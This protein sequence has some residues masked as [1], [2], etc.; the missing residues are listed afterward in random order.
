M[1]WC[2]AAVCFV[3][4]AC[5]TSPPQIQPPEFLLN[6]ALFAAPSQPISTDDLFALSEPMKLYL[7]T[8]IGRQARTTNP[9]QALIHALY[10]K[11]Q[12][13][14]RYDA[15]ATRNAAQAFEARAGNC[16]S[17]VIMT[18]AFAKELGLNVTYQSAY[19]E[20]MWSRSGDLLVRSGHVNVTLDRSKLT[21]TT[22]RGPGSGAMT[23]DFQPSENLRGMRAREISEETIVAMYMNNKAVESLVDGL[24]ANA[25]AWSRA[26]IRHSPDFLSSY[27]TLG[28]IYMRSGEFGWAEQAF[29]YVL[30]REP[31][32]ARAL[33]N[34]AV[35]LSRLGREAEAAAVSRRLAEIEPVG[36]FHYFNLGRV[37]MEQENF[38]L[39]RDLFTK[40]VARAD[41]SEVHFWL[42]MASYKLGEIEPARKHLSLALQNS[43]TRKDHDL[44]A[45]KLAWLQ[46]NARLSRD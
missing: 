27:N 1:R 24:L 13:K 7:R 3:L 41:Y 43:V 34:L 11:E 19:L 32:H 21:D 38:R 28:V 37:A 42:A 35:S 36:P 40:E 20:E 17:L 5:A 18:A 4:A 25:Y 9:Q 33:A 30:E 46:K 8:E 29:N 14:L 15:S 2:M 23:I 45:A 22:A 10:E 12:L 6:D 16:L 44:Y 26:A 39:A 31:T